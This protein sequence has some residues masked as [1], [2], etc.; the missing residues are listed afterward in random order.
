M[1]NIH[2]TELL[3]VCI[4]ALLVIGPERLPAAVRTV[5]LWAGRLRRGFYKVKAEIE[6]EINAD[7]IRRQ[8]HNESVLEDI[9]AARAT[10]NEA[11]QDAE[12]NVESIADSG[13]QAL[14]HI[15]SSQTLDPGAPQPEKAAAT[16]PKDA[17][18]DKAG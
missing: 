16:A 14:N 3:L 12:Q 2:S 7:E 1:F 8:L 11:A 17:D 13:R 6:H 4:V 10:V 15:V 9:E 5:A 18:H